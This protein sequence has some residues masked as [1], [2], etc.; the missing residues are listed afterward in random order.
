MENIYGKYGHD[1]QLFLRRKII[2]TK[3]LKIT[4]IY[5]SS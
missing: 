4:S 1:Y 5:L 3:K 2:F